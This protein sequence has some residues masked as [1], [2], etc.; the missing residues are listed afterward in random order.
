MVQWKYQ[1]TLHKFPE[2]QC[3]GKL[4]I[5]CDQAGSCFVHDA[6]EGGVERLEAL[7]REKGSEGWELVQSAYHQRE[8]L[9]IWKKKAEG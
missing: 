8:L 2:S 4:I 5:E 6:C 3:E 1:V 9:C 7:F